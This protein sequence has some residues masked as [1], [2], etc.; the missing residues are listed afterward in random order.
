MKK[1]L[2]L[3]ISFLLSTTTFAQVNVGKVLKDV[4]VDMRQGR[5]D[6]AQEKL[7]FA[8]KEANTEDER[9]SVAT[10]IARVDQLQGNH[11]KAVSSLLKFFGDESLSSRS[12]F[13]LAFALSDIFE[14]QSLMEKG[15]ELKILEKAYNLAEDNSLLLATQQK[16]ARIYVQLKQPL[17]AEQALS[18][19]LKL[20]DI[21]PMN[22]VSTHIA[23]AELQLDQR[24]FEAA[25]VE[26]GKG[27]AVN[28]A[29]LNK[30]DVQ[31][32]NELK[33]DARM[34]IADSYF[35]EGNYE[36]AKKQYSEILA[37][38]QLTVDQREQAQ[39]QLEAIAEAERNVN[40]A[41]KPIT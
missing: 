35:R 2:V 24:N 38:K 14:A 9:I 22:V 28:S 41:L 1:T 6:A 23:L 19:L 15:K 36:M 27:I 18:K 32:I 7:Q 31:F 13:N 29:G 20:K 30:E 17:L 33:G 37:G 16:V 40:I 21:E 8:S 39:T 26:Y 5:L 4:I 34:G 3:I 25:R 12:R 10:A 11:E